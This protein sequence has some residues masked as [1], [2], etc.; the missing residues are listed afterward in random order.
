MSHP[1]HGH[2]SWR[3]GD[4]ITERD[5]VFGYCRR[6]LPSASSTPGHNG[7]GFFR[8]EDESL[9]GGD[10]FCAGADMGDGYACNE[11]EQVRFSLRQSCGRPVARGVVRLGSFK[12]RSSFP[13]GQSL[14]ER[15]V[16]ES[17]PEPLSAPTLS[18]PTPS[19]QTSL[20]APS[21]PDTVGNWPWPSWGDAEVVAC[22]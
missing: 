2:G 11:G 7:Y 1:A 20:A 6:W 19:L 15:A 10:I 17:S 3:R 4:D 9:F 8:L 13:Y 22:D 14:A 16:P 5:K 12:P 21:Q 18:S